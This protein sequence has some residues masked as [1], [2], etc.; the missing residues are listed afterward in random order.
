MGGSNPQENN[1]I[2]GNGAQ[3]IWIQPGASGNQVLGNQIG[4]AGPSDNG[5]YAPRR[6]WGGR[7][8]DRVIRNID[9]PLNIQYASSNYI[10]SASGGN[11][12]SANGSYGVRITGVGANRN[13]IQGNF[14][15]VGPGGGYRFG[16]GD[17]GNLGD[18]VRIEDGLQ[19]QVGGG[20][21]L[22]NTI[23]TN[24]GA[25][26]YITGVAADPIAG[27]PAT[28]TGNIVSYNMIGVTAAGSQVLGN[29]SDGVS[30]Y[31]PN[32]TIGP[33]NVISQNLRGIGIY[34]LGASPP[35]VATGIL[36]V[37]NLIG[38]DALGT[39]G[40]GN[41]Y[42]GVRI[43]N[44]AANTVQGNAIGIAGHLRQPGRRRHHRFSG[45]PESRRGQPDR[46]RQDGAR[47]P[48]QQERLEC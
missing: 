4:I 26:V 37:D 21:G 7:S 25:G 1:V 22:G 44:S 38:T 42:E 2:C 6:Q 33:G 8:P 10:G 48:G 46:F 20:P 17:P 19:N 45:N 36:V 31:S 32:N 41:A 28:G 35:G 15:G 43:D 34:G 5:L 30:V 18:G 3:G 23:A 16:T 47:R 14:I 27:T 24:H 11:L 40:F 12:I 9:R 29:A 39:Q 13:L